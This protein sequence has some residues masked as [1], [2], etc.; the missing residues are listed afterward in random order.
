MKQPHQP[1][2]A[3]FRRY[4]KTPEVASLL[5]ALFLSV[6]L[7][8]IGAWFA[9]FFAVIAAFFALIGMISIFSR[10]FLRLAKM[11]AE[12]EFSSRERDSLIQYLKDA[13]IIY[14]ANFIVKTFN[15]AAEQLFQV[16]QE[17]VAEKQMEPG[18][19]RLPRM[20]ILIQT[21]FPSLAPSIN[22]KSEAGAWPQVVELSFESPKL[23]LSTTLHP[24][25]NSRG[26][27]QWFIKTVRDMT[28]EKSVLQTKSD[29]I[30]VAA[31]QLRTP[32]TAL[33][34]ALENIVK[35]TEGNKEV[36]P[37]AVEALGVSTRSLKITND[38]LDVSKIEEGKFGYSF[39]PVALSPFITSLLREM[40]VLADQYSVELSLSEP[41]GALPEAYI[42]QNRISAVLFNL[43]DNAIRY[44][45]KNGRVTVTIRR[46]EQGPYVAV[47]V[48]DTGV[49][50]PKEDLPKLFQKLHRG[51]NVVQME[52][53]GSGLGLYIAKNIV[54]RHGGSFD[55]QSELHRGSVFSFTLVTDQSL[56]PQ[57]EVAEDS[58]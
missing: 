36:N 30:S 11:N 12:E 54:L 51:S 16:S 39:K 18:M 28:R 9:P 10:G 17:E 27:V 7:F 40:K 8:G 13:V 29:F 25:R 49:G 46:A 26:E 45:I 47:S 24:I 2:F 55:V 52:P 37:I 15:K 22:Q 20:R 14:D 57:R 3:L 41:D 38:L 50:I 42:D 33:H 23:E 43:I 4:W 44:N 32:L 1:F 58:A 6:L 21:L 48:A 35:F 34:W 53:N 5:T 19:A 31:H 56:I